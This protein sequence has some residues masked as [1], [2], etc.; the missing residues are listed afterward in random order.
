MHDAARTLDGGGTATGV[1]L[2][3]HLTQHH[4]EE[5]GT[6][7]HHKIYRLHKSQARSLCLRQ[8]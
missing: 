4:G 1:H 3:A 5:A 8:K 7:Q 2:T 6:E